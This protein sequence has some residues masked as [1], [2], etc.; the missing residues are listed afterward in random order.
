M[1][2]L[3]TMLYYISLHCPT[4]PDICT[5]IPVDN[6]CQKQAIFFDLDG[7]KI[8]GL[9]HGPIAAFRFNYTMFAI[10]PYGM[11]A[12]HPYFMLVNPNDGIITCFLKE[13][14]IIFNKEMIP[15]RVLSSG[16]EGF[17]HLQEELPDWYNQ[18]EFLQMKSDY[19]PFTIDSFSTFPPEIIGISR[20]VN[21]ALYSLYKSRDRYDKWRNFVLD[22]FTRPYGGGESP[23]GGVFYHQRWRECY[24]Y[25]L[26]GRYR[27]KAS[28]D[29]KL[30]ILAII[31][32]IDLWFNK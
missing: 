15:V 31:V 21:E 5:F 1:T 25:N 18:E 24:F 20:Y 7:F 8:M 32:C 3:Y 26:K 28:P 4:A 22:R 2:N 27:I 13:N 17:V 6:I 23:W 19:L 30:L 16:N 11:V 9:Y 14:I 29:L 12:D 10:T